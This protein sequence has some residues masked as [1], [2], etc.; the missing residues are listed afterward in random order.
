MFVRCFL[1]HGHCPGHLHVLSLLIF[2]TTPEVVFSSSSFHRSTIWG[3]RRS[4]NLPKVTWLLWGKWDSS[5]YRSCSDLMSFQR[6]GFL[7][8]SGVNP[9][10]RMLDRCA[11]SA[12]SATF[13]QGGEG[14]AW[15]QC[16]VLEGRADAWGCLAWR[17]NISGGCPI[18]LKE[19]KTEWTSFQSPEQ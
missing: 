7:N 13:Y 12:L 16:P 15:L 6:N 5:S 2:T 1:C 17:K 18:Y 3:S 19:E 8:Q 9:P 11:W 14:Q 10:P 4:S